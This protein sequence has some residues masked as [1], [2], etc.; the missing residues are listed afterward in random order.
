MKI[1]PIVMVKNEARFIQAVLQPLVDVFGVAVVGDTGSTDDT[2]RL[3]AEIPGADLLKL[4]S[5]TP[6]QLGAA[7]NT[8]ADWAALLGADWVMQVDGDELYS[9]S[10]LRAIKEAPIPAGKTLGFTS[11]VSLDE[12]ETGVWDLDD[13]FSRAA[14]YPATMKQIGTYP[15]EAPE[16][17]HQGAPAYF[18]YEL[19]V[20]VKQHGVHLHR[21][22]RSIDDA[23]VYRRL[24]KQKQF[25]MRDRAVARR[26]PFDL[27]AWQAL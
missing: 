8:L 2:Q 15:F 6:A 13:T 24:E 22:V 12:D 19:P 5:L 18:Y 7:R 4:G 16:A 27:T 14:I 17:W 26:G 23:E 10:A 9:R 1:I 3:V 20:G 21:L 25:A 11:L